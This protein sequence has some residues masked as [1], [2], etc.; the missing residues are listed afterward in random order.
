MHSQIED[1]SQKK[2]FS[3][4]FNERDI[5]KECIKEMYSF[6]IVLCGAIIIKKYNSNITNIRYI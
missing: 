4:N 2:L 1:N 5:K 6:P 3:F